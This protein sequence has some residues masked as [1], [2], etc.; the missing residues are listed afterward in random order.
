MRL[1]TLLSVFAVVAAITC[2][3]FVLFPSFSLQRF[4]ASADM[5][6]IVPLQLAGALFG[7]LAVMA[8]MAR[9]AGPSASRDGLI[10]GLAALNAIATVV[11]VVG[12]RSGAF[13]QLAWA[14][15]VTFALFAITFSRAA[16]LSRSTAA[17]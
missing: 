13:N 10:L 12:A 15:V 9:E 5:Q 4:G 11:T 6:A 2:A 16:L 8:W 17:G 14:P 1:N 7:G 3:C